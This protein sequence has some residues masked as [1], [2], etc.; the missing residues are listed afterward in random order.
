MEPLVFWVGLAVFGSLAVCSSQAAFFVTSD[1]AKPCRRHNVAERHGL[2]KLDR[3]MDSGT[4]HHVSSAVIQHRCILF[5][6]FVEPSFSSMASSAPF[7]FVADKSHCRTYCD[8]DSI[9]QAVIPQ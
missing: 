4:R 7:R 9:S 2:G 3:T 5:A 6:E 8:F 1:R